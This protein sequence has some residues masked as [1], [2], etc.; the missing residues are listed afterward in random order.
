MNK[1]GHL[2]SKP[3]PLRPSDLPRRRNSRFAHILVQ[4]ASLRYQIAYRMALAELE[5]FDNKSRSIWLH[6]G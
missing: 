5:G 1:L 2:A 4:I 3:N 6:F